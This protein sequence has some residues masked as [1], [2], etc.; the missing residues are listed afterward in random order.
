MRRLLFVLFFLTLPAWPQELVGEGIVR[1]TFPEGAALPR[2]L[3]LEK[4]PESRG[5]VPRAFP[6]KPA[7][8]TGKVQIPI[9]P[10]DLY[11]TGEVTGPLRRNGT[12]IELWNHDNYGYTDYEGRR[13]YQSHPWVLGVRPDGTAFGVL[14][15]TTWRSELKLTDDAIDFTT[16]APQLAVYL[17]DRKS[18]QAVLRGLAEL[19]GTISLPPRWALG[20]QQCRYS[21]APAQQVKDIALELRQRDIPCDVIWMDIDY[22]DGYRVFTFDPKGFPDPRGLSDFLHQH[23]FKGIWMIDPGVKKE[24]GYFVYDSGDD[25]YVWVR[26]AQGSPYVGKVWPGECQFPDFTR[27]DVRRWWAGLYKDF[28]AQGVDGVWNDMNEPAVFPPEAVDKSMPP[29][30]RHGGGDGLPPG[31][32]LQY[33]NVYGMLMARAT[34]EGL[35]AA[36]PERRPFVLT[37]ANY[38]GGHRYAATWTGDNVSKWDHL[39]LSIP[40]S[41]SLSLSGQP[42]NGPDLGGFGGTATPEL[43]GNWVGFGAFFPF[44]RAHSSKDTPPKEPWAFG[45][46]VEQAARIALSRRYRLMPYLYTLFERSSRLGDPVMQPVFFADP[47]NER[48]RTEQQAFLLGPDL[49]VVPRWASEPALPDGWREI[50]LVE[51]DHGPYQ[52]RLLQRPGSIIAL[53]RVVESTEEPMLE[54]LTLSVCLDGNGQAEGELYWDAGDGFAHQKGD[55]RRTLFRARRTNGTV[56]VEEQVLG[57]QRPRDFSRVTGVVW[58]RSGPRAGSA[59]AGQPLAIPLEGPSRP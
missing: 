31:P 14:F 43:W 5:P 56:Q 30:A 20:F 15:D 7:F 26:D 22:M 8:T 17:I 23:A 42:F 40:M 27:P 47:K 34:R 2:S 50:T 4:E 46:E 53:G 57:G 12:A 33:H 29:D 59:E 25:H 37:R 58:T 11:A 51:G 44:C 16:R 3:A 54:P 35:L 32:H 19:T 28:L 48:L 52:A 41:L 24:V 10:S 1:Y 13:L 9:P 49:M 6:L 38:L 21:Y 45:P 36:R 39:K 18:P 55:F